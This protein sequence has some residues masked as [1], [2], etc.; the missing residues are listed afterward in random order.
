MASP[1]T[2]PSKINTDT[3]AVNPGTN[4]SKLYITAVLKSGNL[5]IDGTTASSIGP[6]ALPS[7]IICDSFTP[8]AAGQVAYY[9]E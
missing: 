2:I 5:V 6:C 8:A 1:K 9:E 7:P 3:S 4:S